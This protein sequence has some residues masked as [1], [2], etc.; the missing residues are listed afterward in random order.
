MCVCVCVLCEYV[1]CGARPRRQ[2]M[3]FVSNPLFDW[4]SEAK[5]AKKQK[6]KFEREI[7]TGSYQTCAQTLLRRSNTQQIP[8]RKRT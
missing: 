3:V 5:H 7:A 8:R 2:A 1:S 4:L 6:E